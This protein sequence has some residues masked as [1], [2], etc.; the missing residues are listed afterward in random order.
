LEALVGKQVTIEGNVTVQKAGLVLETSGPPIVLEYRGA[1]D[2][3]W[4]AP[5]THVRATG[6]LR[7][8]EGV[9]REYRF[10]LEHP[11]SRIIENPAR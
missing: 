9:S 2:A 8:V 6:T 4:P 3:S 1:Q 5:G 10:R 7:V 11:Q